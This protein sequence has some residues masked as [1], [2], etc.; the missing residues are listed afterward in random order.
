LAVGYA[1][2]AV[3]ANVILPG[4]VDT[5][6]TGPLSDEYRAVVGPRVPL[7]RIARPE[8]IAAV[9]LFLA[10]D[11]SSYVTGVELP[12]DGDILAHLGW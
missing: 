7:G 2:D 5:T 6:L 1:A 11:E 3:R 4:P 12:V 9:A 10:S 8:E